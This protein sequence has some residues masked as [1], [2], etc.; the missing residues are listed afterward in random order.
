MLNRLTNDFHK[1]TGTPNLTDE[2]FAGNASGVALSTKC[3]VRKTD[4]QKRI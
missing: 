3:S 1:L 2:S 4:E